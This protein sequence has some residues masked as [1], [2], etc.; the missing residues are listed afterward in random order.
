MRRKW[1]HSVLALCVLAWTA[2]AA[3]ADRY[4]RAADIPTLS[5]PD[6][7]TGNTYYVDG[8]NGNDSKDGRS[9][10]SAFRTISKAASVV[11]A[12]DTVRIRAGF[13]RDHID[14]SRGLNGTA[15]KP[16]TFGPY[17]N[18]EVIVDGSARVAWTLDSGTVWRTAIPPGWQPGAM[19]VNEIPLKEVSH[20]QT[21]GVPVENRAGVASGSGKWFYDGAA[22]ILYA[23][24]GTAI[25]SGDPN[26]AD[27]VVPS[28]DGAQYH[29]IFYGN[30]FRFYGLT[31]RGAGGP[32]IWGYGNN[33]TVERCNIKFNYKQGISFE[34][35]G[36]ADNSALYNHV[37]HNCLNNWPRGN[38]DYTS[39]SW[40]PG[41]A[42]NYGLRMTARGNVVHKNGGEGIGSYGIDVAGQSGSPVIDGNIV[43][44]NWSVNI[45][46]DNQPN[47][48]VRNNLVYN[49][50]TD[51]SDLFYRGNAYWTDDVSRKLSP[52]GIM[53]AD[54]EWSSVT[55]LN[56]A[57]NLRGTR[58]YNNL[59]ANTRV[60]I[61]DYAE[62]PNAEAWH[63]LKDTVIANNTIV[64]PTIAAPDYNAG[65]E[66]GDNQTPSGT[67]RNV[68]TVIENNVIYGTLAQP[69]VW[70]RQGSGLAGVVIDFNVYFNP[71]ATAV[72]KAG[73]AMYAFAGWKAIYPS[74]DRNSVFQNPLL[75]DVSQ[76]HGSG[77]YLDTCFATAASSPA[78]G[79]GVDLSGFF[80]TDFYGSGRK[81]G[82]WAI[83][84]IEAV[85]AAKVPTA[86]SGV[87]IRT[88]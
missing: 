10:A 61:R 52:V 15:A 34:G 69:L 2:S 18:G 57:A 5:V 36:N 44:D 20:G 19:V 80:T 64:L 53:L 65:I 32:G 39:G 3:A 66:I 51:L 17:G 4:W 24:M 7:T 46:I 59:I 14:L 1:S 74:N 37:Y 85:P 67:N 23:D 38:N 28:N 30:Y 50:D 71:N 55:T 60:A 29:V 41:I 16:I 48:I 83:G 79:A 75:A 49:H 21:G 6:S 77:S 82:A 62:G 8:T 31:V 78:K 43:Y 13:Y 42:G 68:N 76:L 25:G 26:G 11:A 12:G 58:V 72:F 47:A 63:G 33:V 88:P 27:I 56:H 84:A 9:L 22:R 81:P 73:S 54:E 70:S 45:Y 87:T 40:P 35:N 86:P